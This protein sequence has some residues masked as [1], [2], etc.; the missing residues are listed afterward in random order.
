MS[1]SSLV[2]WCQGSVLDENECSIISINPNR[3]IVNSEF[4]NVQ[5]LRGANREN[6]RADLSYEDFA[7]TGRSRRSDRF[8]GRAAS[9]RAATRR[10]GSLAGTRGGTSTGC[11]ASI[12]RTIIKSAECNSIEGARAF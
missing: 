3:A 5:D 2:G 4:P 7:S 9:R 10:A 11:R 6:E 1:A 12:A 8:R